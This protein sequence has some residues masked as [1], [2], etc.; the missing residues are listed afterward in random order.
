VDK[1]EE[2]LEGGQRKEKRKDKGEEVK[3]KGNVG[4]RQKRDR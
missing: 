4:W 3:K 2:D 1:G